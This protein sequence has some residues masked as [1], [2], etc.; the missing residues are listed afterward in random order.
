[1][2]SDVLYHGANGD[3]ILKII[4]TG[5]MVPSGD[6][7]I[8]FARYKW[9]SALMHGGDARR[10]ASFVIKVRV[11]IPDTAV[12]R[13]TTTQG[14]NDTLEVGTGQPLAAEV[15]EMHMRT[16]GD[17]VFRHFVGAEFIKSFLGPLP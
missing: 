16:A 4:H 17:F 12:R 9:D 8:W 6:G 3:N 2:V 13:F 5:V 15:L 7:K 11:E 14:V 1:M 10:R